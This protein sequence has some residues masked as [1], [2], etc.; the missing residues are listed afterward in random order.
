ML[1]NLE[2]FDLLLLFCFIVREGDENERVTGELLF[3]KPVMQ[4]P[5]R[6]E[7]NLHRSIK[8]LQIWKS[9]L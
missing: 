6:N 4:S 8:A 1:E 2:I 3:H 7:S 9:L 5:L